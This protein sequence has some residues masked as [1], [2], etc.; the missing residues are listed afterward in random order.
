MT[1]RRR[2][3]KLGALFRR[4]KPVDDIEEEIRAHLEMEEREN[5][6]AGMSP[7]EA[8]YAALRRFGNVPLAQER[9]REMWGWDSVETLW[10]DIRYGL[11]MLL[12]NPGFTAVAVVTLALGIG[13]NTAVFSVAYAVLL[14][15]LPYHDP[16]RLLRVYSANVRDGGERWMNSP[17]DIEFT[18]RRNSDFEGLAYFQDWQAAMTG[19][20]EPNLVRTATV[21]DDFF[22][23]L[24]VPPAEG[25]AFLPEEHTQ[26]R[27]RVLVL[28]EPLRRHLFGGRTAIG[29][30]ITLDGRV[31]TVVGVMPLGFHFPATEPPVKTDLWLPWSISIDMASGN[32]DVAAIARLKPGVTLRQAQAKLGHIH[33]ALE[34]AHSND[35]DWRLRLVPLQEDVAGD[36]RLPILIIFGA[37][38]FVLL[39][40]CANVANLM[41][42][43]GVVRQ[44]EMAVRTALGAGRVRLIRQLLTES[45]L[46][47]FT[48]GGVGL[49]IAVWG[50]H[51]LRSTA[52]TAIPRLAEVRLSGPVL[53]FTLATSLFVGI[54]FGLIP[55]LPGSRAALRDG[56]RGTLVAAGGGTRRHF[57]NR[58]LLITQMALSL[59]LLIGAGLMVKSFLLL[60]SVDLGFQPDNVLTFWT[61]LSSANNAPS[62]RRASFY[63]QTLDRIRAVPGVEAVALA[64]SLSLNGGIQVPARLEG[65]PTPQPG[66]ETNVVYQAI[67]PDYFRVMRIPLLKGR[68]FSPA[69]GKDAPAVIV[70]NQ[71][72]GRKFFPRVDPLGQRV[73][74]GMGTEKRREVIGVVGDVREG[75][76][77]IDPAPEMYVPLFQAWLAPGLPYLVRTRAEPL[78][79]SQ[80]IRR[81]IMEVD[82]N[83]PIFGIETMD[84]ILYGASA[85]PRLRTEL[86]SLFSLLALMLTVVGLYGVMAYLVS[87]RSHEIG[88]RIALGAPPAGIVRLVLREGALL[89][90]AGLLLGLAGAI[91]LT[92]VLST[93]LYAIKPTD[94]TTFLFV[95]SLMLAVGF[96]ACYVPA[97]RASEV[98]PMVALRHE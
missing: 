42:A 39:I 20:G 98:D 37:V 43:R 34:H 86:L 73:Y 79:L 24:G 9:S 32:R 41:L 50:I 53:L 4:R 3:S 63:Q 54:V 56:P 78:S 7:E 13:A 52:T 69:D 90:G 46:L 19:I 33:A 66:N 80:T 81:A 35:A 23:T 5:L 74:G 10:Q 93:L 48:G 68:F 75:G 72:F 57:L 28:S 70:V 1:L 58:L 6:E 60:T 67:T 11:R 38:T 77:A 30:S 95:S 17:G 88:V 82:K 14:K 83:Q 87:Q 45:A 65:Q 59:V 64:S 84:Q 89:I 62:I 12:K 31:C 40:A 51:A 97:R 16:G 55:A 21:S 94:P 47:S 2:L 44:R 61:S 18:R 85:P 25:R 91:A 96:L 76:L 26:G 36:A 8:Y 49:A 15:P 29:Q 71:A 92:R 27:D 22:S